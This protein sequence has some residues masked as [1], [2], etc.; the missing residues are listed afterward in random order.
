MLVLLRIDAVS[1]RRK[2][3]VSGCELERNVHTHSDHCALA[4]LGIHQCGTEKGERTGCDQNRCP[5]NARLTFAIGGRLR[6]NS[7]NKLTYKTLHRLIYSKQ[8][9]CY[10]ALGA[11]GR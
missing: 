3:P 2:D 5:V 4:G 7:G 11:L 10:P 9:T 6:A 8:L 1:A